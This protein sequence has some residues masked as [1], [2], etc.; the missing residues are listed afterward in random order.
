MG[1]T[2]TKA[3]KQ[4]A[5]A[6]SVRVPPTLLSPHFQQRHP[7]SAET[8]PPHVLAVG[9]ATSVGGH[10]GSPGRRPPKFD[11]PPTRSMASTPKSHSRIVR[12][13][14]A[15]RQ[16]GAP[17]RNSGFPSISLS[18]SLS[19]S[20]SALSSRLSC[21]F[22]A[23]CGRGAGADRDER[24]NVEVEAQHRVTVGVVWL[25]RRDWLQILTKHARTQSRQAKLTATPRPPLKRG[26]GRAGR[27]LAGA[28]PGR[29][30]SFGGPIAEPSSPTPVS[31]RRP[32]PPTHNPDP[33]HPAPERRE[34]T[35]LATS[36]SCCALQQLLHPLGGSAPRRVRNR[37]PS[38]RRCRR[39]AGKQLCRCGLPTCGCTSRPT[40]REIL[41]SQPGCSV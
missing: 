25:C 17:R 20:L 12:S 2:G 14:C 35:G 27:G 26:R 18:L 11:Q 34:G 3:T 40:P 33:A 28:A 8:S 7:D 37:R 5:Q 36:A 1:R 38:R 6:K 15:C 23:L 32:V 29:I 41:S 24:R 16:Q 13:E 39:S 30:A 21:A 10:R 31:P 19:L 9:P 22:S 4:W